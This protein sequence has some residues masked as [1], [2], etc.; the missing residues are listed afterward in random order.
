MAPP[1]DM[2][3]S[4]PRSAVAA[5][6]AAACL[7]GW[8]ASL[9]GTSGRTAP[10]RANPRDHRHQ[11]SWRGRTRCARSR[12]RCR[13]ATRPVLDRRAPDVQLVDLQ[14]M[15]GMRCSSRSAGTAPGHRAVSTSPARPIARRPRGTTI[16]PAGHR[17]PGERR[18]GQTAASAG[19]GSAAVGAATRCMAGGGDASPMPAR[20]GR[21][22]FTE[23]LPPSTG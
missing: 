1:R 6:L 9:S 5:V 12:P 14:S 11:W 8:Q 2:E 21:T 19:S 20:S 10:P 13:A 7:G 15:H 16:S 23:R 22:E 18:R 3:E 17:R 4:W